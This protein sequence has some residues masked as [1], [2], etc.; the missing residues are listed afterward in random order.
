[1][2]LAFK[3]FV[4]IHIQSD[5]P[6]MGHNRPPHRGVGVGLTL[7]LFVKIHIQFNTPIMGAQPSSILRCGSGIGFEIGV[8]V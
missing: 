7:R 4:K 8:G 6:I 2:G 3:L 1:M 5:T